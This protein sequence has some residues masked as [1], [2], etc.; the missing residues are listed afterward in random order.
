METE[1]NGLVY[2]SWTKGDSH[3]GKSAT[4]T[5]LYDAKEYIC[6]FSV[7]DEKCEIRFREGQEERRIITASDNVLYKKNIR[8]IDTIWSGPK[9]GQNG[10]YGTEIRYVAK[11]VNPKFVNNTET[12]EKQF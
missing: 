9:L 11:I 3:F 6:T 2:K 4:V 7:K 8:H 10:Y 12:T 5:I 1:K